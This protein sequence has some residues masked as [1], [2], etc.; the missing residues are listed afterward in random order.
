MPHFWAIAN[1]ITKEEYEIQ[2]RTLFEFNSSAAIYLQTI[3]PQSWVT[4]FYTG[5]YFGHKTSNVVE[6]TNKVFKDKRELP[7]IDLLDAIWDYVAKHRFQ[8]FLK[9]SAPNLGF[10]IHTPFAYQQLLNS[11]Q[12]ALSN[13]VI[14]TSMTAGKIT[15]RN[16]KTFIVDLILRTCSCGH[17]QSNGIP[18]GHVFSFISTLQIHRPTHSNP[19]DYVPYYF[20]LLAW[21]NTYTHNIT[22]ISLPKFEP[23]AE[24]VAPK[25]KKAR[26]RPKVNRYTIGSKRK[27]AAAQAALNRIE[28]RDLE[29][30]HVHGVEHMVIIE[31]HVD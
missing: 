26:G 20:S 29:V 16:H 30:N 5:Q 23:V 31:H 22:A 10:Q 13:T 18:C 21:K 25:E 2:M 28:K 9:A 12:W 27:Q 7:I 14:M 11:Q 17:F 8:R 4:A 3:K 24:I 19:R 6:S 15:Q 1:A